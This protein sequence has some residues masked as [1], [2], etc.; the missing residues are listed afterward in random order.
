MTVS[1]KKLKIKIKKESH[2][3]LLHEG[4]LQHLKKLATVAQELHQPKQQ[5]F[6]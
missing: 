5:I 3:M 2:T 6:W 1:I 4:H